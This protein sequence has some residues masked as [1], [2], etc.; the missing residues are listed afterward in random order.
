LQIRKFTPLHNTIDMT[1]RAPY[2][3]VLNRER[4]SF[5]NEN[6]VAHANQGLQLSAFPAHR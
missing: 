3:Y 1:V 5:G 2:E 4:I 6:V